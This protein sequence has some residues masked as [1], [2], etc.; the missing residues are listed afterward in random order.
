[1]KTY[2][3]TQYHIYTKVKGEWFDKLFAARESHPTDNFSIDR[4]TAEHLAGKDGR[5][6]RI[7]TKGE[8][9]YGATD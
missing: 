1:M 5:V 6:W 9:I 2:N 7:E 3:K 8:Q 4:V